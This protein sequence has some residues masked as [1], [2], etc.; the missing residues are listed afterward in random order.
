MLSNSPA[1]DPASDHATPRHW[2][3]L[4]REVHGPGRRL[5]GTGRRGDGKRRAQRATT[6]PVRSS[7]RTDGGRIKPTERP[8]GPVRRPSDTLFVCKRL[9]PV[10][11]ANK[12][13]QQQQQQ[14]RRRTR[15][16]TATTRRPAGRTD[17]RGR[18]VTAPGRPV[19]I[20]GVL[21]SQI[22]DDY[23]RGRPAPA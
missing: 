3:A 17:G 23:Q 6:D 7:V 2:L 18:V 15:D 20:G 11:F 4:P 5:D 19:V 10:C 13:Q 14:Q 12:L 21:M 16:M 1:T 22:T 8:T 9:A